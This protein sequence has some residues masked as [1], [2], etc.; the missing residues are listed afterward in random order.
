MIQEMFGGRSVESRERR[1]AGFVGLLSLF[2]MAGRFGWPRSRTTSAGSAT[3]VV[4][5][6]L[7]PLLYARLPYAGRIGS[8]ALFVACA[9]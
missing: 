3:Y 9:A 7:G 1:P 6:A 4:F 5:F 2:N 8:V